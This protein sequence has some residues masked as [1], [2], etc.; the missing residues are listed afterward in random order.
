MRAEFVFRVFDKHINQLINVC[1]QCPPEKRRVIPEGF[2]NNIHWHLGHV[3]VVMQF[4]VLALSEQPIILPESYRAFFAYGTKPTDWKE[5]PPEWDVLI[6]K[7][8]ELRNYIHE[9]LKDRLNEPV[10][11]NFLQAQN[12]GELIHSTSL[13]LFY[14]QGIVYGMIKSLKSKVAEAQDVLTTVNESP[15]T[16]SDTA[17]FA[18]GCF[19]HMEDTFQKL[20]GV[21]SVYT[22]YTGGHDKNPTYKKVVSKT[23]DH[24]EA[25][26]V[27]YNPSVIMYDELLQIFWRNVDSTG[28]GHSAIFYTSHEQKELAEASRKELDSSKRFHKPVVTKIAA[29]TTFYK[30]EDEHQDYYEKTRSATRYKLSEFCTGR[31]FFF[32]QKLGE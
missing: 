20:D 18:G 5:E 14:H 6:A 2:K 21:S 19:W 23:S 25:V 30:A 31:G 9:T 24:L 10:K 27:H 7:L 28:S 12:I 17:I 8:K 16:S 32:E 4:D 3:L 26:E 13:H 22:G 29:A 15:N 1:N 11:E